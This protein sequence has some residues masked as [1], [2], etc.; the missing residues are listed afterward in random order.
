[1]TLRLRVIAEPGTGGAEPATP[2]PSWDC[3]A[4][5]EWLTARIDPTWRP[6]EW[7]M[8]YWLF[9]ASP[10]HPRSSVSTCRTAACEVIVSP[11]NSTVGGSEPLDGSTAGG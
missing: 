2:T 10:D 6:G 1:V 5:L 8:E 9:T 3:A 4:W 7:R 11:R